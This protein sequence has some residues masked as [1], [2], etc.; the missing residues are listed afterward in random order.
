M[1][2]QV[3]AQTL[4]TRTLPRVVAVGFN[5]CGT[6]GLGQLFAAAGHPMVHNKLR[7]KFKVSHSIGRLMRDNLA[8][9][10]KVFDG[11]QE[12]TFYC[13]LIY[14]TP[15]AA[16]DG[17]SAYREI[18]RDYPDTIL[19]LNTRDRESWIKSRLRHGHGHFAKVQM[20]AHGVTTESEICD[21]WRSEWDAHHRQLTDFMADK[22]DQ[23]IVFDIQKDKIED[24]IARLPGY[25]LDAKHWQDIGRSRDRKMHPLKAWVKRQLALHKPRLYR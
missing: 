14:T 25:G 3:V 23:L 19:L 2:G 13:D 5:K 17:A 9:G 7:G 11:A 15:K 1:R 4:E 8:A 12:Y 24:L 6:R 16:Y 20:Q 21:I 10:R 18:L 22:S